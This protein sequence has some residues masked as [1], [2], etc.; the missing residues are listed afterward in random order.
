MS[1]QDEAGV[2]RH[3]SSGDSEMEIICVE[4]SRSGS[5]REEV[6]KTAPLI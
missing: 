4:G 5:G 1:I 6:T 3:G 2:L